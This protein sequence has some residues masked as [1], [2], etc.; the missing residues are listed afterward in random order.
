MTKIAERAQERRLA[1]Q[2]E[3]QQKY[4]HLVRVSRS[5]ARVDRSAIVLGRDEFATPLFLPQRARLEH[6]H[7]IGTTGGGKSSFLQHC[8][9]QDIADGRGVLYVDPH[10]DHP[11]SGYRELLT[12]LHAGGYTRTRTIH[13]IDP[14]ASTHTVGFNPLERPDPQ[15]DL[16]VIAGVALEAFERVWGGED[17]QTKPTIRRVLKAT[18]VALAQLGLTLVEAGQLYDPDDASGVRGWAIETITD[19]YARDVLKRLH[20]LAEDPRTRRDFGVEVVGPINRLSEFVG[21]AA[22]RSIV[23]QTEN[24]IDLRTAMDEGHVIL[25]N[26]SGGRLVYER[27]ADLLGRLLT[28]F[29]FFHAK[30]RHHPER[31]FY[32]YLDECHR[33][34]S[35]DLENILAELRKFGCGAVLSHQW[36]AQLAAEDEN[37][38][39]A[40]RNATNVKVVFRIKDPVEATELADMVLGYNLEMPVRVLTKPAVVGHRLV[41]LKSES[42]SEQA[43]FTDMQSQTEGRSV[44]ESEGWAESTAETVG[45]AIMSAEGEAAMSA[46]M[47]SSASSAASGTSSGIS[48]TFGVGLQTSPFGNPAIQTDIFGNPI[49]TGVAQSDGFQSSDATMTGSA[50]SQGRSS[51]SSRGRSSSTARTAGRS[52]SGAVGYTESVSRSVGTAQTRGQARAQGLQEAFEPLYAE[53]PTSVHSLENLRYMAGQVLCNLTTGRAAISFVDAGGMKRAAL[54]VANVENRALPATEFEALR[55]RV[56][57]ASPSATPV[58]AAIQSIAARQAALIEAAGNAQRP[59]ESATPAQYRIKK[60]RPLARR[61]IGRLPGQQNA[62]DQVPR[63]GRRPAVA[64]G[65]R[66]P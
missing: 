42:S 26:L 21:S 50:A 22:I 30:R 61:A 7:V 39:A 64:V 5:P 14:N 32:V 65:D 59:E 66:D 45:E 49:I 34:L 10:G 24:T 33:Y 19:P 46:D 13:L 29:L 9:R 25:V 62:A 15:T 2:Q 23:G 8:L 52:T 16:S 51:S 40:V 44:T 3:L 37:M 18:F 43:A 60:R 58:A 6:M 55:H 12:W 27:D 4:P 35:G 31:P 63:Q 17:T 36:Q 20:Q 47:I 28:R 53:Q 41:R 54:I 48:N 38:L 1:V 57:E 11:A 56:F